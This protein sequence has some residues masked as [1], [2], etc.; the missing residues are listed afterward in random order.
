MLDKNS[1]EET[2]KKM[3]DS[4]ITD[5]LAVFVTALNN[6]FEIKPSNYVALVL[7]L[8]PKE[9]QIDNANLYNRIMMIC[10]YVSGMPDAY[11]IRI[12][13]KNNGKYYIS[14]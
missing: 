2:R 7:N 6:N 14:I 13:K 4:I 5:L 8:L 12:Q 1:S 11:A 9:H 3:F 10:N